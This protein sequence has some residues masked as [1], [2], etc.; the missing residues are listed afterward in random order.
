M[1]LPLTHTEEKR[2]LKQ[3]STSIRLMGTYVKSVEAREEMTSRYF[4]AVYFHVVFSGPRGDV[5]RRV[6]TNEGF[7]EPL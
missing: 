3:S 7:E 1:I 5:C 6:V 4:A 2:H